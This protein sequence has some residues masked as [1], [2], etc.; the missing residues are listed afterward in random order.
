VFWKQ[1]AVLILLPSFLAVVAAAQGQSGAATPESDKPAPNAPKPLPGLNDPAVS[2]VP[3][4]DTYVIGP[5]DVLYINV[6]HDKDYT[7]V[8]PVSPDGMI[9]IPLVGEM[10]A[11]GLTRRQLGKQ[12]TE[13][14]S[15]N[16]R[17]PEV[18]VTIYDVR[19]KKYTV[20]GGA[21]RPG[22][23]PL[24]RPITVFEAI[25]E[26]GGFQDNFSNRKNILIIRGTEQFKFSFE[27]YVKGKN[28]DK[29]IELK[30]GDTIYIKP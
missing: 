3:V 17:D 26:A 7:G 9:T 28:R 30:N 2:G 4:D 12:L 22:S 24:T 29:N 11:D 6:F 19:S 25:N 18:S 5:T 15:Q 21:K 8:Y 10:K 27:D 23:Y 14:L 1:I 13:A 16:I 20:A